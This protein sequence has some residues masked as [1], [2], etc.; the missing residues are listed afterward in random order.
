MGRR[1]VKIKNTF[2]LCAKIVNLAKPEKN[3]KKDKK[4]VDK[5]EKKW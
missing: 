2:A 1:N 3:H 5:G 4:G